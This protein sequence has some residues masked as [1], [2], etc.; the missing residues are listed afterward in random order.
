MTQHQRSI[1]DA[2]K[3]WGH[4]WM[5]TSAA[6]I[7]EGDGSEQDHLPIWMCA[8][9]E[10]VIIIFTHSLS[11]N[12]WKIVKRKL[13]CFVCDFLWNK[14]CSVDRT[15]NMLTGLNCI[16]W[17]GYSS[18]ALGSVEFSVWFVHIHYKLICSC[19][20]RAEQNN[21]ASLKNNNERFI[22]IDCV[23]E[24]KVPWGVAGCSSV[25]GSWSY[26]WRRSSKLEC[27][28]AGNRREVFLLCLLS[29]LCLWQTTKK[30]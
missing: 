29:T 21:K 16:W 6:L 20:C 28:V 3:E 8:H 5:V 10:F 15:K 13:F 14:Y 9:S 12:L 19:L 27:P 1:I 22:F 18:G 2:S 30:S 25:A 4:S 7:V 26:L 24:G 17:W 11:I 23:G